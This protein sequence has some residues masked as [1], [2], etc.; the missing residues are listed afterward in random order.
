M[1]SIHNGNS[2]QWC[3]SKSLLATRE[4]VVPTWCFGGESP[5]N[6]RNCSIF[7]M[8]C[9]GASGVQ[10]FAGS[11]CSPVEGMNGYVLSVN[12]K[13]LA[14]SCKYGVKQFAVVVIGDVAYAQRGNLFTERDDPC[15]L[16]YNVIIISAMCLLCFCRQ[17][18]YIQEPAVCSMKL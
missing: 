8:M 5:N 4:L 13:L 3:N 14:C 9:C 10:I 7:S 11:F 12:Q 18:L 2:P 16:A 6:E 1:A 15:L 17:L